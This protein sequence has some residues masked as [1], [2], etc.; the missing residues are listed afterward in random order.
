MSPID[1]APR[2]SAASFLLHTRVM[3]SKKWIQAGAL[4]VL[5]L[6]VGT[7]LSAQ[8]RFSDQI[9]VTEVEV[10]VRVLVKG[11]TRRSI[12]ILSPI[13]WPA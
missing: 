5:C 6:A 3:T 2:W 8:D 10:P 7:A 4:G 9:E 13:L 11:K 12:A 1:E